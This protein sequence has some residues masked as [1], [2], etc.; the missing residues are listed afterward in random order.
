MF[1]DFIATLVM[2]ERFRIFVFYTTTVSDFSDIAK[3]LETFVYQ[4]LALFENFFIAELRYKTGFTPVCALTIFIHVRR[5]RN[6]A[7]T[8]P[9]SRICD[10]RGSTS[11]TGG[12]SPLLNLLFLKKK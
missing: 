12:R 7:L 9:I 4:T 10:G 11:S 5:L 3:C 2:S 1:S 6:M 8:P